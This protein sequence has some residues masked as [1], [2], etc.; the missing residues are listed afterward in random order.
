MIRKQVYLTEEQ[1]LI[2][3]YNAKTYGFSQ[4]MQI[5]IALD[6]VYNITNEYDKNGVKI[7]N[8][9]EFLKEFKDNLRKA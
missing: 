1:D 9:P 2:L 6:E 3:R 8:T 7:D 5:R 4:A